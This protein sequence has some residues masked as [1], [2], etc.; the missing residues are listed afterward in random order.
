L[1][2]GDKGFQ[3]Q[4]SKGFHVDGVCLG[5]QIQGARVK[6]QEDFIVR[7]S[8]LLFNICTPLF[9]TNCSLSPPHRGSEE[10]SMG[11]E[12]PFIHKNIFGIE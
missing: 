4:S 11:G 1:K 12:A 5:R 2:K 8:S 9:L 7:M 6:S 10:M 3:R